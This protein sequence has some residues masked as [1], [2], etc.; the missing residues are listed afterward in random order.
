MNP[1][2]YLYILM[3]QDLA[4]MNPGKAVAQG[5]HAANQMARSARFPAETD[6]RTP[7]MRDSHAIWL[8]SWEAQTGAGFGTTITLAVGEREMR[9]AVE[10]AERLGLHAGITHDPTYPLW[11]GK[12][13]HL[14]PLDTCGFVFG[15]KAWCRIAV[16]PFDLMA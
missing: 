14:I 6:P 15:P 2:V 16:K 8:D 9:E 7:L 3:R 11:D 10:I 5:A 13:L 1:E 12:T 4:S